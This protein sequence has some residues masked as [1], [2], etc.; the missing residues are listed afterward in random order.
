MRDQQKLLESEEEDS[1]DEKEQEGA[2]TDEESDEEAPGHFY[3]KFKEPVPPIVKKD[4]I[5][6]DLWILMKRPMVTN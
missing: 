6:E 1:S 4:M 2:N 5:V 3:I